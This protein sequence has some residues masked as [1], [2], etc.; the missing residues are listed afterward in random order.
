MVSRPRK[1]EKYTMFI[2]GRRYFEDILSEIDLKI[3]FNS[4]KILT[5]FLQNLKI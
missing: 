2:I 5:Q 4:N 3:Q 1:M